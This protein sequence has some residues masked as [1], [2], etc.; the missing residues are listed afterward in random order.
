MEFEIKKFD[1]VYSDMLTWIIANQEK[2]TDFN[3]GS[4]VASI[5]EALSLEIEQLYIKT[6][7]GFK[8]SMRD[9]PVTIFGFIKGISK[10]SAGSVIFGRTG[11]IGTIPIPSTTIVT[12]ADGIRFQTTEDG[13][14]LDGSDSSSAISIEA[15]EVGKAG[16]VLENTITVLET[17]LDGIETVNNPNKTSGGVDEE[18]PTQHIKR[19][20]EYVEGLGNANKAGILATAKKVYGVRSAQ[21]IEHFPPSDTYH[22]SLYVEDG[23]GNAPDSMIEAVT[24]AVVGND[25]ET[26]PGERAAGIHVRVLAPVKVTQDVVATAYSDGRLSES[27]IEFT[28]KKAISDY[29]NSLTLG[30]DII[31]KKIE[32][33]IMSVNG[34]VD[35]T[36]SEPASNV[37]IGSNQIAKPGTM[38]I[39]VS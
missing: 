36:V 18:S 33:A 28:T 12:T 35:C 31:K 24:L 16:N 6:K 27:L 10:K 20:Q 30:E 5:C 4:I 7:I 25:S 17:S 23:A 32:S 8:E 29:I 21:I 26:N 9:I 2:L 11:T 3:E 37:S 14:I 13:Q 1:N 15:I 39:T 22:F 19:F 34:I 38:S